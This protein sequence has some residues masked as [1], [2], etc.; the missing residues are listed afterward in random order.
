MTALA[1]AIRD[2][3]FVN[4][5]GGSIFGAAIIYI[6]PSLIYGAVRTPRPRRLWATR[7]GLLLLPVGAL[8]ATVG[9]Y[10]TLR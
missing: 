10:V 7:S 5:F 1:L 3:G 6:F 9:T 2:V 8:L 4:S